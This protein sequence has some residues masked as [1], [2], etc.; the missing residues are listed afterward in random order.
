MLITA[1]RTRRSP[2]QVEA[3]M[4]VVLGLFAAAGVAICLRLGYLQVVQYGL[5]SLYAS[6]QHE[7][8]AR[9]FPSRGQVLVRDKADG[10]LHPLATNRLTWQVY[11]VPKEMKDP[12]SVAHTLSPILQIPD[13]DLIA[14][15]TRDPNDPYELLA[16]DVDP[17]VVDALR[18]QSLP[19][20]GFVKTNARLYPEK[21]LGGQI[22]GFVSQDERGMMSGKYGIE[23]AFDEI[24][25]GTPGRL[26]AEKDAG[27]RRLAIGQTRLEEAV[28][29]S[30]VVLTI[31][32]TIQFKTCEVIA[33]AVQR[34][35]ADGGSIVVM[36]PQTGAVMG[37]CSYPDFDPSEYGKVKDL[38]QLNN[39]V[40][41]NAYEPG[42]IF[43]AFTMAGGLDAEK[44]S[45]KSVYEDTGAE[46]VDDRTIKNSD[47]KAHG[48]QT[49]TQA[50]DESLNTATIFVQR[51]LGK[52]AFRKYVTS[53]G[54][55]AK[56]GIELSPESKGNIS[57]LE[58][59]GNIFAATASF[60]QGIT[61][62]PIQIVA[63]YAAL[64]NG[65]RLLRPYIVEE[66]IHPDGTRERTRPEVVSQ[67][68]SKRASRL[69]TGMLI[70]AVENGH[71]KRAAVPGYWVAGKT[72]T[73]QVARTDGIVGYYKDV[74]IGSFAG[75][76]PANDP[77]FV[78]LV[79]IDHPRDVQW[80]EASAA[81]VF[82]EMAAFLL[83]YLEVPPER[84][85][86]AP[87][88]PPPP[89]D[90]STSTTL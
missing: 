8:A 50:L 35:G 71:G 40:T 59:K 90:A 38:S 49:M 85:F 11:A 20:I 25:A 44:I 4:R 87:K 65:G 22:L 7:L 58:K 33:R 29:G 88:P 14:K 78:M 26:L 79:K 17:D 73:A 57:S 24:L 41:L 84:P 5:Y 39:P 3:R 69:I 1:R 13:V 83:T 76:A 47:G 31:D 64:A 23:G 72:G 68:V 43:K 2:P 32:R 54:F 18:S 81:P 52:D 77:K 86:S 27:G 51:Q 56:T 15:L 53:F 46:K 42:S 62:T 45:P 60:G 67:P 37:M 61:T 30:D 66:I 19:G 75:Y 21:N 63:A 70:S 16:K 89:P 80:A 6:D 34:H 10:A 36:N 12:V 48:V 9:L 74:T 55:G 82:G 28:N